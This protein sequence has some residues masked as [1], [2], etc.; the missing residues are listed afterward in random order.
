MTRVLK[1]V[2][3]SRPSDP[4]YGVIELDEGE[5]YY[6][7]EYSKLPSLPHLPY[8]YEFFDHTD[9]IKDLEEKFDVNLNSYMLIDFDYQNPY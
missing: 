7:A 5:G 3:K 6:V 1:N 9:T 4:V 8:T 2:Y